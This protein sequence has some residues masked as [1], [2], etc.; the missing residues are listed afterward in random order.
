MPD[1]APVAVLG[2]DADD[3]QQM[4]AFTA[5]LEKA[6]R[7]ATPLGTSSFVRSATYRDAAAANAARQLGA[8]RVL[9]T[10]AYQ[11][12]TT[13]HSPQPGY[14]FPVNT[15]GHY[16][17]AHSDRNLTV[18]TAPTTTRTTRHWWHYRAYF[19]AE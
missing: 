13:E 9:Y 2:A 12:A 8:N 16:G 3:P 15:H 17:T 5:A 19:F 18:I 11:N 1:D 4:K 14:A 7:S 6:R 10:F